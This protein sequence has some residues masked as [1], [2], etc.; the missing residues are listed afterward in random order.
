MAKELV[1]IVLSCIAWDPQL[2]QQSVLIL[3]DNLTLVNAI[4]KRSSK[5]LVGVEL[6]CC[7]WLLPHILTL[8]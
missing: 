2:A 6:Q 8:L 4:N 1:L 3:C 7:L 5:G